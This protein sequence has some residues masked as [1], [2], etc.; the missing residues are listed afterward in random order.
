MKGR[1]IEMFKQ[2]V[3][4]LNV[5]TSN[6]NDM[7]LLFAWNVESTFEYRTPIFYFL[8]FLNEGTNKHKNLY[9]NDIIINFLLKLM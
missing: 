5:E 3:N 6:N 7:A 4:D 1:I 9:L 2:N 8:C